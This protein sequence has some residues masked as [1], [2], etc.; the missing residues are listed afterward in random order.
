MLEEVTL[1][2]RDEPD[3]ITHPTPVTLTTRSVDHLRAS[4]SWVSSIINII[5]IILVDAQASVLEDFQLTVVDEVVL[6]QTWVLFTAE[7]ALGTLE[8]GCA[9][10]RHSGFLQEVSKMFSCQM[11][12][13]VRLGGVR[14][15]PSWTQGTHIGHT[16]HWWRCS[17]SELRWQA[18][19]FGGLAPVW[20]STA[21]FDDC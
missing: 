11:T 12:V 4:S 5:V 21:S 8:Q 9:L 17:C 13:E 19:R 10:Q 6:E 2:A 16:S 1:S 20:H 15:S 14:G 7:G 3:I 18:D